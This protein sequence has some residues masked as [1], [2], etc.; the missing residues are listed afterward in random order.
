[1]TGT[2]RHPNLRDVIPAKAGISSGV[3]TAAATTPYL[4][5]IPAFAGKTEF[6]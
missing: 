1:M 3:G 2:T 6:A 4:H 5:Q